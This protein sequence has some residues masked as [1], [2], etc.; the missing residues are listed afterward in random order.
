MYMIFCVIDDPNLLDQVLGAWYEIG[1][2]GAT[3]A[4]TTGIRR[5][6]QQ[7]VPMRY[8]H[9]TQQLEEGNCTLFAIVEDEG[10]VQRSLAAAEQIVGD[11]DLPNTGVFASW[12]VNLVKGVPRNKANSGEMP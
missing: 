10:M 1:V 2:K 8:L 7:H 6:F 4:E 9:G 3:I 12:Q 11:F 5:K